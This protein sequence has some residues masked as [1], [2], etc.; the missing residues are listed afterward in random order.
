MF[1]ALEPFGRNA[2]ESSRVLYASACGA[3]LNSN[4]STGG[5]TDDTNALQAMLNMALILGSAHVVIEGVALISAPLMIFSNTWL[6]FLPGAGLYMAN[7]SNC[8]ALTCPMNGATQMSSNI[9]VTGYGAVVNMNRAHNTQGYENWPQG[10]G[11]ANWGWGQGDP[12]RIGPFAVWFGSCTGVLIEG[13][14]IWNAPSFNFVLSNAY[15]V[16]IRKCGIAYPDGAP[17][18]GTDGVHQYGPCGSYTAGTVRVTG[19]FRHGGGDDGVALLPVEISVLTGDLGSISN[20]DAPV[21]AFGTGYTV[22]FTCGTSTGGG[23]GFAGT[24]T[25]SGGG[26][27][28]IVVTNPG[29]GYTLAANQNIAITGGSGSGAVGRAVCVNG[30][31]VA[32]CIGST[33]RGI[34]GG[35][36]IGPEIDIICQGSGGCIRMGGFSNVPGNTPVNESSYIIGPRIRSATGTATVAWN[37]SNVIVQDLMVDRFNVQ[38]AAGAAGPGSTGIIMPGSS[39]QGPIH[40]G[41]VGLNIPVIFNGGV[42]DPSTT[43]LVG[44]YAEKLARLKVGLLAEWQFGS[45]ALLT[46]SSGNGNTLTNV[47]TVTSTAGLIGNS[48]T[49]VEA[50]SQVLT[51][52]GSAALNVLSL[53]EFTICGFIKASAFNTSQDYAPLFIFGDSG[54]TDRIFGIYQCGASLSYQAIVG[55]PSGVLLNAADNVGTNYTEN[56]WVFLAMCKRATDGKYCLFQSTNPTMANSGWQT[57]SLGTTSSPEIQIGGDTFTGD[58]PIYMS[59]QIA[60]LAIYDR[61]LSADELGLRWN[62][63]TGTNNAGSGRQYPYYI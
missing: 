53:P 43:S 49:F 10:L 5:G 21:C 7:N 61:C 9:R 38:P 17:G 13:L 24:A 26:V 27:V 28:S 3:A 51:L 20:G 54:T 8:L 58:G 59:G 2:Y 31:I 1:P 25:V 32:V 40:I 41:E 18:T 56:E 12:V 55:A 19:G 44:P 33:R 6:E 37:H 46:D 47:N 50:S 48:A 30:G 63:G 23:S 57:L 36:I 15:D 4:I 45:G 35:P 29:S 42:S 60:A 11:M 62:P 22:N 39:L 14:T 16:E 34:Y 52:T